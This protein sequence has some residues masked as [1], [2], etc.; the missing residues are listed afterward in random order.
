MANAGNM[1]ISERDL[2]KSAQMTI[3]VK[4]SSFQGVFVWLG[5][6]LMALGAWVAGIGNVVF[7]EGDIIGDTKRKHETKT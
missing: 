7:D 4:R 2:L 3:T 1:T 6:R 5:V